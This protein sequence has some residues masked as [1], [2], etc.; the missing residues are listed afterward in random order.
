[1]SPGRTDRDLMQRNL[2]MFTNTI[3]PLLDVGHLRHVSLLQGTKA[4]GVHLGPQSIPCK[5]DRPRVE[6]D[7]FY[8]WQEDA[9]RERADARGFGFTVV[10]PQIVFGDSI[11]SPMNVIP[12]L[13]AYGALLR[14]R[15]LP[16][17]WPGGVAHVSEAIDAD[18]LADVLVWAATNDEARDETFNVA[19]GDVF[20][21]QEV[22]P[23]IA[24]AA[25]DG[26]RRP[27]TALSGRRIHPQRRRVGR[28]RGAPSTALAAVVGRVRRTV[29]DLRRHDV[30]ARGATAVADPH[31]GQ[32]REVAPGR[33]RGLHRH[34]RHV[35]TATA[36]SPGPPSAAHT[37]HDCPEISTMTP[38]NLTRGGH[39]DVRSLQITRTS[40]RGKT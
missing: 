40:P 37:A 31:V 39:A 30:R 32:H 29:A 4:Y 33:V 20:V 36:T 21:W 24:D 13:G 38:A 7:N 34:R 28:D 6:H 3:D 23:A 12:V 35:P 19:N 5:E 14:E 25:R 11:G 22:W 10:R 16:L 27:G 1:M 8:F 26:G 15:G 17:A 2:T 18:L 9:L